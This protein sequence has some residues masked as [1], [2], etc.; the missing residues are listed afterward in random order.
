LLSKYLSYVDRTGEAAFA[1]LMV[2]IINGYVSLSDLNTGF[3][4]IIFTNLG[5]CLSWGT[6][7][8]L[9]YAIS[10]AMERNITRNKLLKFKSAVKNDDSV[11]VVK[12]NFEGTFL[13]G[14]SEKAKN[15]IAKEIV[16]HAP[17]AS[18]GESKVFTRQE[19][20]GWVSIIA[21]YMTV[22]L[23]LSLPYLVLTDK[24]VAWFIANGAGVAWLVWYAVQ[25]GKDAGKNRWLIGTLMA[26]VSVTFLAVSYLVWAA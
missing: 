14:F 18:V 6:I 13:D 8:G 4:Y 5:A 11:E 23:L 1:V 24:V 16:F 10:S 3:L 26:V 12:K 9:I 19:L 2:I 20:M 25:L 21:I 17:E 7:D 22:G 15:H